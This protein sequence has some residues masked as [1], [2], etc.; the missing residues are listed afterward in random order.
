MKEQDTETIRD[1]LMYHSE[2]KDAQRVLIMLR[3]DKCKQDILPTSEARKFHLPKVGLI[4]SLL[5][6]YYQYRKEQEK[7]NVRDEI[8]KKTIAFCIK[9]D[10]KVVNAISIKDIYKILDLY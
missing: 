5:E 10:D 6:E 9:E 8:D 2:F 1:I 7:I 4:N 3:S